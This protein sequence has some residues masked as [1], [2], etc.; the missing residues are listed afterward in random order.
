[1]GNIFDELLEI[2][3]KRESKAVSGHKIK[4]K[5]KNCFN[6]KKAFLN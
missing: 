1:M 6:R 3:E 5:K 4:S 2:F